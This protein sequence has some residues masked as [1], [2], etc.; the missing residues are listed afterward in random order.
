MDTSY[1]S[2]NDP[3]QFAQCGFQAYNGLRPEAAND[4]DRNSYAVY[5]DVETMITD[6]WNVSGALR[7]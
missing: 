3:D 6:A 7:Y 1:P 4:S 5:V 2:V